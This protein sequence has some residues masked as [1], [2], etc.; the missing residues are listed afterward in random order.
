MRKSF[1]NVE[2]TNKMIIFVFN[3]KSA[4]ITDRMGASVL[5]FIRLMTRETVAGG[6]IPLFSEQMALF[7]RKELSGCRPAS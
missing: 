7:S 4:F 3:G 6:E 1:C 5:L 2:I